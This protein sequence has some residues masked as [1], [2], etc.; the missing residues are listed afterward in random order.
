[1]VGLV[2]VNDRDERACVAERHRASPT[3]RFLLKRPPLKAR[4]SIVAGGVG[5]RARR[6]GLTGDRVPSPDR[7]RAGVL[8]VV[9]SW[10]VMVV[11]GSSLAKMSEHFDTALH[12]G[13]GA[14]HQ[15]G[16]GAGS[17]RLQSWEA[18]PRSGRR[19]EGVTPR[20]DD[21]TVGYR[22]TNKTVYSAKYHIIWCP[23]Y[24]RRILT[25]RVETRLK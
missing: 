23:K 15:N 20:R 2:G 19:P 13:P 8:M 1:M 5:E 16:A 25:G 14:H 7:V 10:T 24:R 18:E 9:A 17:P 11:A 6:Y 3:L 4:V 22:S 21:L 12:N